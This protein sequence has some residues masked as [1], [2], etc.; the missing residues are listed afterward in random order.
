MGSFAKETCN[1][2]D[3]IAE[4]WSGKSTWTA[5][6]FSKRTKNA[7][8][9][10]G[11]EHRTKEYKVNASP[12]MSQSSEEKQEIQVTLLRKAGALTRKK[13]TDIANTTWTHYQRWK[14]VL[15]RKMK[16]SRD[17]ASQSR[18][19]DVENKIW[20]HYQRC[21]KS[22]DTENTIWTHYWRSADTENTTWTHFLF[23][24]NA[25]ALRSNVT[26]ISGKHVF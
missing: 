11:K 16:H 26:C 14:R 22:T 25:L 15:K 1:L 5:N 8:P 4:F 17:N 7:L 9:E 20:T 21:E 2:I 18:S 3:P 19:T 13:S 10:R 6:V 23:L 12:R 24:V